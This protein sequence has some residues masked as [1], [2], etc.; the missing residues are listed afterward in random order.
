MFL[1]LPVGPDFVE[2]TPPREAVA[3]QLFPEASA[4]VGLFF[5]DAGGN[6]AFPGTANTVA[7]QLGI[8]YPA[9]TP[10]IYLPPGRV[11]FANSQGAAAVKCEVVWLTADPRG[12][13]VPVR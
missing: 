11:L 6:V 12:A 8:G 9:V 3:V 13:L 10:P 2:I 1:L 4:S 7:F 5:G